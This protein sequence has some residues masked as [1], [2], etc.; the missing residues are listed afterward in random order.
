MSAEAEAPGDICRFAGDD[1]PTILAQIE[2]CQVV[3]Q[4]MLR[5]V[6][7]IMERHKIPFYLDA[8][9]LLGAYRHG[10]WIPW[11]DD[12]DLLMFR[13]DYERFRSVRHELP[14]Q[15]ELTD[16]EISPEHVTQVPRIGYRYS[17]F[18]WSERLGIAPPERQRIVLD[19]FLIDA[20]FSEGPLRP[21]RLKLA[22]A[23][24]LALTMR[25]TNPVRIAASEQS[26]LKRAVGL[27]S[28]FAARV[29]PRKWLLRGY[30]ALAK[31]GDPQ[32]SHVVV[33]NHDRNTRGMPL[34]R[35]L[36]TD[37]SVK[38]LFEGQEYLCPAPEE[39]LAA[40]FGDDFRKLPP[41]EARRPHAAKNFWAEFQGR[42]WG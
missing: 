19:I 35:A 6:A 14:A 27:G 33:L 42:R 2:A 38:L 7:Q 8:G 37:Q 23:M 5:E 30:L 28:Y 10:G 24:R 34:R 16:A 15:L 31:S 12:V 21:V 13:A 1:D 41:A 20:D 11:D 39:Y 4:A 17:G 26:K 36:F 9:T 22:S 40:H 32:S 3:S 29:V 18:Q 25:A